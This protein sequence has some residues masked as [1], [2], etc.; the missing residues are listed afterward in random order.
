MGEVIL[1]GKIKLPVLQA[2][3]KKKKNL[4]KLQISSTQ[5]E[6]KHPFDGLH[7][8]EMLCEI[9]YVCLLWWLIP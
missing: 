3:K 6:I 2:A 7:Y 5:K 1:S 4:L 8:T 9:A